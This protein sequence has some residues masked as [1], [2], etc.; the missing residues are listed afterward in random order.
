MNIVELL[1]FSFCVSRNNTKREGEQTFFS[2]PEINFDSTIKTRTAAREERFVNDVSF[3][4][5]NLGSFSPRSYRSASRQ[6][7]DPLDIKIEIIASASH[8]RIL[9]IRYLVNGCF[10]NECLPRRLLEQKDLP[11]FRHLIIW[12]TSKLENSGKG[13]Y[14]SLSLKFSQRCAPIPRFAKNC[15]LHVSRRAINCFTLHS[16]EIER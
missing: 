14:E 12:K 10:I 7:C 6:Q 9:I 5:L 16:I 1:R 11:E 15:E 3:L 13:K 4:F 2:H 8:P